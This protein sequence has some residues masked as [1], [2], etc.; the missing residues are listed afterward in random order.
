M[1]FFDERHIT[2]FNLFP[3]LFVIC[4]L[5]FLTL[6]AIII[7]INIAIYR[8]DTKMDIR[9]ITPLELPL[10]TQLFDYNDPAEMIEQNERDMKGGTI[11]IFVM[12][13]NDRPIGEL[14]AAYESDDERA[15]KE[16][17]AYL[18]AYRIHEDYQGHGYG[19]Q[20]LQNVIDTLYKK[21]YT[22]FTVGVE[23]D[24]ARAKHIYDSFGFTELFARKYEEYQGDGYEYG[25]YLR[26]SLCHN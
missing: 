8:N 7:E 14:H 20:L 1:L 26:R 10:L 24:N 12:F 15:V 18:F 19:K 25:L 5:T 6:S 3:S 2:I 9:K 4:R 21:G 23:D 16:K 11:D 22:E 13:D 17:R